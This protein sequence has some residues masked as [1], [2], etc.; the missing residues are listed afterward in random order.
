MHVFFALLFFIIRASLFECYWGKLYCFIHI[1]V[2]IL[3]Q[4]PLNSLQEQRK[5]ISTHSIC[6]ELA[7]ILFFAVFFILHHSAQK[8]CVVSLKCEGSHF[9]SY[10][11]ITKMRTYFYIFPLER[12]CVVKRFAFLFLSIKS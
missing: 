7:K 9:K 12:H 5:T 1:Y 10:A 2:R 6:I 3:S 4:F 8:Y 11:N